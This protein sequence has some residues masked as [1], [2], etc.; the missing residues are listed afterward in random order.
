MAFNPFYLIFFII[1]ILLF[2]TSAPIVKLIISK[3]G[4]KGKDRTL[5][6]QHYK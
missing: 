6:C 3:T 1:I 5:Q 2:F 4:T